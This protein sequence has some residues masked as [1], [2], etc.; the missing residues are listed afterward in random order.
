[1]QLTKLL[2]KRWFIF[3]FKENKEILRFKN[4]I[5]YDFKIKK[6]KIINKKQVEIKFKILKLCNP[7]RLRNGKKNFPVSGRH[8]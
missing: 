1:M 8:L 7:I 2:N 3:K 6:N 5:P 4:A